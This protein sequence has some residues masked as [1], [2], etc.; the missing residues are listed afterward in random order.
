[1]QV[2]THGLSH[3][4]PL[5]GG[6]PPARPGDTCNFRSA[7]CGGIP[8]SLFHPCGFGEAP[9]APAADYPLD[10]HRRMIE[11]YR[12]V[13]KYYTGD[14]YPL[15]G[16]STSDK[17]WYAYQLHREDLGEGLVVALRRPGSPFATA[18]F[19]LSDLDAQAKYAVEDLDSGTIVE[20]TGRQLA[21][22]GLPVAIPGRPGSVAKIYRRLAAQADPP[23]P[24]GPDQAQ[25]KHG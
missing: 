15:T 20:M 2:G 4:V 18:D 1:M 12:R 23:R 24:I 21:D 3:W 7:W 17:D 13:R 6:G 16:C 19:R 5:V 14:Y 9:V 22:P 11:D 25:D 8:F 10:W